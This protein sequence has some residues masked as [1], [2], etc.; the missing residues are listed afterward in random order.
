MRPAF[1]SAVERTG[2]LSGSSRAPLAPNA[3]RECAIGAVA[4][5]DTFEQRQREGAR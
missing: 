2:V 1:D 3:L 4:V 5:L